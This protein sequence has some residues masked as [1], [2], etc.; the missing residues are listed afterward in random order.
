MS[1]LLRKETRL[2]LP[3]FAGALLLAFS[4]YLIPARTSGSS[5]FETFLVILPYLLC[6]ALVLMMALSSFGS[7]LT[8]GTFSQLLAQPVSRSRVWWTKI[9]LLGVAFLVVLTV[10]LVSFHHHFRAMLASP[11]TEGLKQTMFWTPVLY[12]LVIF[13]GGLWTVLLLRQVAAAFW[14]TLIVPAAITMCFFNL[15]E[16]FPALSRWGMITSLVLYSVAG[17]CFAWRLFLRAQDLPPTS[18]NI[19]LP[20]WLGFGQQKKPAGRRA[21]RPCEAL[22]RKELGLHQSHFVIAIVL[23]LLHIVVITMRRFGDFRDSPGALFILEVFWALWLVMPLLIGCAAVAEER[24]MGVMEPQLCLPVGWRTQCRIKLAMTLLLSLL[25]GVMV[26]L[27]FEGQRILPDFSPKWAGETTKRLL[28]VSSLAGV[29]VSI[30]LLSFYT[31]T[32]TRNALQALGPGVLVVLLAWIAAVCA[33][34]IESVL[35]LP[36]WRGPLIF[37]IGIPAVLFT[38]LALIFWNFKHTRLSS[39]VYRRNAFVLILALLSIATATASVYHRTWELLLPNDPPLEAPRIRPGSVTL[40]SA[41]GFLAAEFS[42]GKVWMTAPWQPELGSGFIPGTNWAQVEVAGRLILGLQNDGSLWSTGHPYDPA[43]TPLTN[44]SRRTRARAYR[45]R[46][47]F[48]R[49]A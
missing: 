21:F 27:A 5:S 30:G 22:W 6:P 41:R 23:A 14:I 29:A 43:S 3:N 8:A 11:E 17:F 9:S 34:N 35:L 33:M 19:A 45:A 46:P 7:E 25:F 37:F 10:W 24:R 32:L 16:R 4:C 42:N 47:S 49:G 48:A 31:S 44:R 26:P 15:P 40:K 13:S 39:S 38:L 1:A 20:A 12:A 2:L 28:P 36:L 18:G